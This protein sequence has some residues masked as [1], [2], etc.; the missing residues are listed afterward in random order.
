MARK[1]PICDESGTR[2]TARV[3]I[4]FLVNDALVAID[5][6]DDEESYIDVKYGSSGNL[7]KSRSS[8]SKA[9]S[10]SKRGGGGGPS[11]VWGCCD[12]QFPYHN[13]QNQFF[14][15]QLFNRYADLGARYLKEAYSHPECVL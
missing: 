15:K 9:K 13:A 6:A 1:F 2:Y 10:S 4:T 11:S 12:E 8:T 3:F 5:Y 14:S 7:R